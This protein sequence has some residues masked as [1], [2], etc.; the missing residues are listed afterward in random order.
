MR[1]DT[2]LPIRMIP[3][4]VKM[5]AAAVSINPFSGKYVED[6]EPLYDLGRRSERT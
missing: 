5:T 6:L 1:I 4:R 2:I 3:G